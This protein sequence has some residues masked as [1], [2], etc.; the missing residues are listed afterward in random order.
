MHIMALLASY[1]DLVMKLSVTSAST[2]HVSPNPTSVMVTVRA[3][4]KQEDGLVSVKDWPQVIS[5]RTVK[6]DFFN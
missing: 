5:V 1:A 6:M 4:I 2:H 3:K